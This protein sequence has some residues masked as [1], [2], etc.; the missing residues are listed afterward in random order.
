MYKLLKF[1]FRR[2]FLRSSLY[3]CLGVIAVPVLFSFY[4]IASSTL[5]NIQGA[6]YSMFMIIR[7][8]I[9]VANLTTL[10]VIF[11]SIYGCEDSARG[12]IKTIYSLGYPRYK[13]FLSK[14]IA[15]STAAI[16]MYGIVLLFS[17]I[18]GLLFAKPVGSGNIISDFLGYGT[19]EPDVVLFCL[20]QCFIILG[21]HAFYFMMSELSRKTG[22]SIVLGIFAP[23]LI[24]SAFGVA[25][26][27]AVGVIDDQKFSETAQNIFFTFSQYWLPTTL[28]SLT[29]LFTGTTSVN[30]W[31]SILVNIGYVILFGGLSMLITYKKQIK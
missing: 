9:S 10:V 1:Q 21:A 23:G 16:M 18:C 25:V 6:D 28:S 24:S 29:Q 4:G 13:I 15:S 2:L 3:V 7:Q 11:T 26:M 5:S 8:M 27:I 12:T 31:I 20:Q 30:L 19:E 22:I 14:F 17:I